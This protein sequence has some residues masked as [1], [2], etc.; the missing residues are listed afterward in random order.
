MRTPIFAVA[1]IAVAL[2]C[3]MNLGHRVHFCLGQ[4][5]SVRVAMKFLT[6][7]CQTVRVPPE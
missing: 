3:R 4:A 5:R 2:G 7:S 6:L 1:L